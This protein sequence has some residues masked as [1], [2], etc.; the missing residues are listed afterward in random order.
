MPINLPSLKNKHKISQ[1]PVY[2][3]RTE[4]ANLSSVFGVRSLLSHI[5]SRANMINKME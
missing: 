2:L 1:Q 3:P 4:L 5:Y